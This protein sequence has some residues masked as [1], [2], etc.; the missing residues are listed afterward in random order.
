[1][2]REDYRWPNAQEEAEEQEPI[3]EVPCGCCGGAG[4]H[5]GACET[6]RQVLVRDLT[7]MQE[8]GAKAMAAWQD[9]DGR[10][11]LTEQGNQQ[12]YCDR[13]GGVGVVPVDERTEE[14]L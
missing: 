13:C 12:A 1:M 10:G 14:V 3:L 11:D 4:T 7:V 9:A 6:R 8:Q 5:L 2:A